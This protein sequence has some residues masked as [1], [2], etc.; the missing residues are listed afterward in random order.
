[1]DAREL[2]SEV[3]KRNAYSYPSHTLL[4]ELD[5]WDSLKGV[6]LVIR[7]EEVIGRKLSEEEIEQLQSI[8][9]VGRLLGGNA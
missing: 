7:I 5:N 4:S 9:D 3:T 2:I 8:D 6:R 1:M